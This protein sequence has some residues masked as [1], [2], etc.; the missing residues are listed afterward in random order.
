MLI[1]VFGSDFDLDSQISDVCGF[2]SQLAGNEGNIF[3]VVGEF[4]GA[5][6]DCNVL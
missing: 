1:A 6:T 5:Q 4:S 3:T 2:G